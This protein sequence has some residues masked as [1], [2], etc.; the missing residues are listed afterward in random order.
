L[1]LVVLPWGGLPF[2]AAY[3]VTSL[4]LA[5]GLYMAVFAVVLTFSLHVLPEST[6]LTRFSLRQ[7]IKDH[8]AIYRSPRV[9]AAGMGWLFYTFCFVS[10]LTVMPP[11]LAPDYRAIVLGALPLASFVRSLACGRVS[12]ALDVCGQRGC[13]GVWQQLCGDGLALGVSGRCVGVSGVG[14]YA[15]AHSGRKLCSCT[16]AKRHC[17]DTGAGQRCYG[18]NG[19][20]GK[21]IGHTGHR[22]GLVVVGICRVAN[23]CRHRAGLGTL[24]PFGAGA[25]TQHLMFRLCSLFFVGESRVAHYV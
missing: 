23:F 10:V 9:A 7:L 12:V 11:F 4:F 13:L 8:G 18:A 1:A 6:P 2:V 5:H 20:S 17:R 22:G 19:Q 16:A 25:V 15:G 3:G 21:Y 24:Y 14:R